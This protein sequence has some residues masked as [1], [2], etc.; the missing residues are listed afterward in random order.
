MWYT[1]GMVNTTTVKID[2]LKDILATLQELKKEIASV[3]EVVRT[4]PPY[5]SEEWW[6]WSDAKA[7]EDVKN[8]EYTP[9]RNEQDLEDF[10]AKL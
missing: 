4:A 2:V 9:V 8:K 3:K 5:G 7:M 6:E 1:S 10:F